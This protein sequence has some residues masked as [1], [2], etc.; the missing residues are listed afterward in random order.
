LSRIVEIVR[1]GDAV[2]TSSGGDAG[3]VL[4]SRGVERVRALATRLAASGWKPD[5]VLCSPRA[6][7][8]QTASLLLEPLASAPECVTLEALDPDAS[9][10]DVER[11]LRDGPAWQSL[12]LVSHMPLV[13]TLVQRWAGVPVSFG[14]GTLV[15][16]RAPDGPPVAGACV[17]LETHDPSGPR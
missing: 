17:L 16:L 4:S 5:R 6:R 1:H 8:R 14:P 2:A 12:L 15:R 13:G 3:R 9:P 7:A 10:E 11:A